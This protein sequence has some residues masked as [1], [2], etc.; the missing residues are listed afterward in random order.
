MRHDDHRL[1]LPRD[2]QEYLQD[3]QLQLWV[4]RAGRLVEKDVFRPHRQAAG[5]RHPL[6]LAPGQGARVDVSFVRQA[7][8]AQQLLGVVGGGGL[9]LLEDVHRP[10][11]EVLQH[12]QVRKQVELLEHHLR[13][14]PHVEHRR[15]TNRLAV[16][17]VRLV[18]V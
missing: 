17:D 14:P 1:F 2:L 13:P 5:N 6:G 10:L 9:V 7:D 15:V 4:Q 3:F 18:K 16:I 8:F 11:D 12:G